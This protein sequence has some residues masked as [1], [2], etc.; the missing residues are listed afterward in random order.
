[1]S[2]FIYQ[3]D[4]SMI[5]GLQWTGHFLCALS[6]FQAL[7]LNL[8]PSQSPPN[9]AFQLYPAFQLTKMFQKDN[10]WNRTC[11]HLSKAQGK[12]VCVLDKEKEL[13]ILQGGQQMHNISFFVLLGADP[14]WHSS[15]AHLSGTNWR[16]FHMHWVGWNGTGS[17]GK[18]IK[19][20]N[21]SVTWITVSLIKPWAATDGK[22][23]EIASIPATQDT[24][25][26]PFFLIQVSSNL[27]FL[28]FF[29]LILLVPNP[30]NWFYSSRIGRTYSMENPVLLVRALSTPGVESSSSF[31]LS[32]TPWSF[33]ISVASSVEG[34][35][36]VLCQGLWDEQ[37]ALPL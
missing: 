34:R 32:V 31:P 29:I 18:L 14:Q 17:N 9:P 37:K 28:Y 26:F 10:L 35:W 15:F 3:L 7:P 13:E 11:C 19:V 23:P 20:E 6:A 27:F 8:N 12:E 1:M 25:Y 30:L 16:G 5:G 4:V 36:E 24:L 22:F 2:K 33:R 21:V